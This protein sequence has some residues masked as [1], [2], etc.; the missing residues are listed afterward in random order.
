MDKPLPSF[1]KAED[2]A[3]FNEASPLEQFIYEFE[4]AGVDAKAFREQLVAVLNY[5]SVFHQGT[6]E[7]NWTC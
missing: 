1:E 4:P 7:V 3:K 2:A 6:P 5:A